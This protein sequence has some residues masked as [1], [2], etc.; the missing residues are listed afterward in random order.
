MY[1]TENVV[2]AIINKEHGWAVAEQFESTWSD[3]SEE[4]FS[5]QN[6]N[7]LNYILHTIRGILRSDVFSQD[8]VEEIESYKEDLEGYL[9]L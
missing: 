9:G 8:A 6:S 2:E 3:R 4:N 1:Y 5:E 7:A